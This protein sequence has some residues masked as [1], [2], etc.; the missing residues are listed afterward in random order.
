MSEVGPD[1][2]EEKKTLPEQVQHRDSKASYAAR[3]HIFHIVREL[4][5]RR[6]YYVS[7]WTEGL[8]AK[9]VSATCFM[10]FT[11]LAP[12]ITLGAFLLLEVEGQMGVI[13]VLVSTALC[14]VIFSVF[15]GQGMV[16]VGV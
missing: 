16:I 5:H 15:G 7:D 10:F 13:E 6:R 11:S 1:G 9:V 8:N 12:G 4:H 2:P 14:G 3:R